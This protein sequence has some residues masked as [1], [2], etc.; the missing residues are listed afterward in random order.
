LSG[1]AYVNPTLPSSAISVLRS[2]LIQV[3]FGSP[4]YS[5]PRRETISHHSV[6]L[7]A[8][9]SWRGS[10][11]IRLVSTSVTVSSNNPFTPNINLSKYCAWCCTPFP[12]EKNS[13]RQIVPVVNFWWKLGT[14]ECTPASLPGISP[15]AASERP[16]KCFAERPH[17]IDGRRS[18]FPDYARR[19]LVLILRAMPKGVGL[20]PTLLQAPA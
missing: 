15:V 8:C 14:R 4:G 16:L 13:R 20:A 2:K 11:P 7:A 1:C 9:G 3:R 19:L 18:S 6:G 5:L 12:Q 17:L 10:C